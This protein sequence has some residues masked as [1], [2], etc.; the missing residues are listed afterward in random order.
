MISRG[1]LSRGSSGFRRWRDSNFKRPQASLIVGQDHSIGALV[2]DSSYSSPQSI[3]RPIN[4]G[5]NY[6][7][8]SYT[9]LAQ[10]L[11]SSHVTQISTRQL[12]A[13]SSSTITEQITS[14][15]PET[16]EV[17]ANATIWG[18]T[19]LLLTNF[20]TYLHLPYWACISLTNV[21]VRSAM[22][23]IAIRGAKT[24][25]KFGSVSPEVQFIIT[26]FTNDMKTIK[27]RG[28][29]SE[30]GSFIYQQ[31]FTAQGR[32]INMTLKT[33]RGIF[34]LKQINMLDIFKVRL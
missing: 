17:V 30:E 21:C 6:S 2:D 31:V 20:H 23:P 25:I 9:R 29:F 13:S 18:A 26:G 11:I 27:S 22:I 34:T 32:L 1:R 33:L 3:C 16:P 28:Q 19:G 14:I 5:R 15:L 4:T 24:Q 8:A 10:P 12:S 7:T